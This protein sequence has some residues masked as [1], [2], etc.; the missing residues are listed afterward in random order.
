MPDASVLLK[1][2]LRSDDEQDADR[3]LSL[4]SAWLTD[5]CEL[6]VPSLSM[7]E[8]G[9]I[10]GMKQPDDAE[11]LLGTMID[12]QIPEAPLRDYLVRSFEL[13]RDYKVTFYDAAYHSLAIERGGTMVTADAAYV[14][15]TSKSGHVMLLREWTL[16]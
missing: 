11:A 2:V 5:A 8:V 3:A 9:N 7:F 13:M 6:V 12:I 16:R 14:R 10:V 15:K 1:W 4:K